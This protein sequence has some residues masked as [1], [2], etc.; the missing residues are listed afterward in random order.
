MVRDENGNGLTCFID[1]LH[2]GLEAVG[3]CDRPATHHVDIRGQSITGRSAS[4]KRGLSGRPGP[5]PRFGQCM[6]HAVM[7]ANA[8]NAR[9][10]TKRKARQSSTPCDECG[11][12]IPD[13]GSGGLANRHHAP[14]CSLFDESAD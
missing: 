8:F 12:S 4:V 14:S 3:P 11:E 10:L 2:I 5:F 6:E 7:F 9:E 1:N 13:I